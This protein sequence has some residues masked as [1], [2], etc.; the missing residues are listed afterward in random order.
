MSFGDSV[1]FRIAYFTIL[2]GIGKESFNRTCLGCFSV[3]RF[4]IF[5]RL[6]P[7]WRKILLLFF[8]V[9]KQSKLCKWYNEDYTPDKGLTNYGPQARCLFFFFFFLKISLA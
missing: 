6:F 3:F 4:S 1:G 5:K 8:N 2:E 9:L 7:S